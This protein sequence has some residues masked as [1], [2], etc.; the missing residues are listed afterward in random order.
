MTLLAVVDDGPWS[1]KKVIEL[2]A[3]IVTAESN[4]PEH[5]YR[6]SLRIGRGY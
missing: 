1:V 2:E 5:K 3:P 6:S 4:P